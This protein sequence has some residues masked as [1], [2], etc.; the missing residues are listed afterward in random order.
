MITVLTMGASAT[1]GSQMTKRKMTKAR[2]L[3]K[4]A[5]SSEASNTSRPD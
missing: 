5:V 3:S 1:R 4:Y 2:N